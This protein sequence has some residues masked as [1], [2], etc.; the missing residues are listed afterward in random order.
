MFWKSRPTE[1]Q[2]N[3]TAIWAGVVY[4]ETVKQSPALSNS[5]KVELIQ[6]ILE[7]VCNETKIKPDSDGLIGMNAIASTVGNDTTGFGR[8]MEAHFNGGAGAL[9]DADIAMAIGL[10]AA[11]VDAFVVKLRAK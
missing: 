11:Q 3:M 9:S 2:M 10:T 8:K 7:K 6:I 1:K 5:D 4:R